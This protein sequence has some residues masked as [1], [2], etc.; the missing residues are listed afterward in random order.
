MIA[1]IPPSGSCQACNPSKTCDRPAANAASVVRRARTA[2]PIVDFFVVARS[3]TVA[4]GF[5]FLATIAGILNWMGSGWCIG[6][7][8]AF[9]L[10]AL[11]CTALAMAAAGL[12]GAEAG[13]GFGTGAGISVAVC[14]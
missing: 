12:A 11:P 4:G 13:R 7:A 1:S 6:T 9:G 3:G 8:K 14:W 2:H 10:L 5:V